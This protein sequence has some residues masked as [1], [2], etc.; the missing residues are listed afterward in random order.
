MAA[1]RARETG[2]CG[3]V[4]TA[5]HNPKCDN[6][7]KIIERDGNMLNPKWEKLATEIVNAENLE[8]FLKEL[9]ERKEEFSIK[10]E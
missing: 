3:V 7:V 2:L 6:G 5:S 1:I 10:S 4:V 8:Q 9:N